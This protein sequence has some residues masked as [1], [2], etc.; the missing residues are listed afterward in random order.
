MLVEKNL[1]NGKMSFNVSVISI[2]VSKTKIFKGR[3]QTVRFL[4][5]LFN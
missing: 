2:G 4:E 5:F 1:I 3:T